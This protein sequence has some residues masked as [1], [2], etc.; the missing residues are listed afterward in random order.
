[1]DRFKVYLRL[2]LNTILI[3][4]FAFCLIVF[5]GDFFKHNKFNKDTILGT[6][7][8]LIFLSL[9]IWGFIKNVKTILSIKKDNLTILNKEFSFSFNNKIEYKDYRNLILELTFKKPWILA[10]FIILLLNFVGLFTN[11]K[12]YQ[13][14]I[15]YLIPFL[16]LIL[17]PIFLI[18]QIKSNY[19]NQK[20]LHEEIFYSLDNLSVKIT[21]QSFNSEIKWDYYIKVKETKRF[22]LLYQNKTSANILN[23]SRMSDNDILVLRDFARYINSKNKNNLR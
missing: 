23:K 15:G 13:T 4:I 11:F 3:L 20:S 9:S 21:G 7:L 10:I 22:F 16:I 17:I 19:K 5:S 18:I 2:S 1:M 6:I 14:N 12:Q 8:F